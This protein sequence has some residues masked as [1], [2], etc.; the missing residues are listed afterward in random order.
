MVKSTYCAFRV[1]FPAPTPGG[2]QPWTLVLTAT[3]RHRHIITRKPW[4][5]EQSKTAQNRQRDRKYPP[6]SEGIELLAQDG[7]SS[8]QN[9]GLSVCSKAKTPP[10][11]PSRMPFLTHSTSQEETTGMPSCLHCVILPNGSQRDV[12]NI[13]EGKGTRG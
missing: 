9:T 11:H 6:G 12:C 13:R 1:Q 3:Y 5:Y 2:S 8:G 4:F 7:N 10:P